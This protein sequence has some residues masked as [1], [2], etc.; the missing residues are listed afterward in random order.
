MGEAVEYKNYSQKRPELSGKATIV[1]HI[2]NLRQ[3][4]RLALQVTKRKKK[5]KRRERKSLRV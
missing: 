1:N 3:I 4:T 2:D 5:G